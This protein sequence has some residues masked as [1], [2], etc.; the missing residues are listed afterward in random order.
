MQFEKEIFLIYFFGLNWME[1]FKD[2]SSMTGKQQ[3]EVEQIKELHK[4]WTFLVLQCPIL[5]NK[6]EYFISIH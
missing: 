3:F 4:I 2:S 6:I 1:S 5:P